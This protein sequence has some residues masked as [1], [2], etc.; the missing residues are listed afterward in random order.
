[1]F[2]KHLGVYLTSNLDW[3]EQV[4]YV[5]LKAN[6]KHGVLRHVKFLNR[7]TLDMLYKITVRSTID[8]GLQIYYHSLTLTEKH[9]ENRKTLPREHLIGCQG[10]KMFLLKDPFKVFFRPKLRFVIIQVL[11]QFEFLSFVTI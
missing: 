10:V 6:Q 9:R 2:N 4:K 1:M 7:S 8:Y 3:A 11:S 5:S